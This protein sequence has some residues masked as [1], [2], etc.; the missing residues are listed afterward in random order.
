MF[1]KLGKALMVTVV[2]M[3]MIMHSAGAIVDKMSNNN[4]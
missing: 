2:S 1:V 3:G 4:E